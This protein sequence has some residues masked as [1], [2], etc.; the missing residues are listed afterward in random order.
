MGKGLI[1]LY[2]RVADEPEDPFRLAVSADNFHAHLGYLQRGAAVVPLSEM[3]RKGVANRIAI[4]FDDGY[5][6]NAEIAAP[7]L[8]AA[9]LPV[10]WFITVGRLGGHPFWWDRLTHAI[11]GRRPLPAYLEIDLPSGQVWISLPTW[12]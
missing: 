8:A 11:L 1:L 3:P 9:G 5:R 6:D 2:H 12:E 4:T 7:A 10:T